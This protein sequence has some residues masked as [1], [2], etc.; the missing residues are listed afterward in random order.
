M[1]GLSTGGVH[2]SRIMAGRRFRMDGGDQSASLVPQGGAF[3]LVSRPALAAAGDRQRPRSPDLA[4]RTRPGRRGRPLIGLLARAGLRGVSL[5]RQAFPAAGSFR[6]LGFL[7]ACSSTR[8]F[9]DLLD[10]SRLS[11]YRFSAGSGWARLLQ[12]LLRT[13]RAPPL[14]VARVV[15]A[16]RLCPQELRVEQSRSCRASPGNDPAQASPPAAPFHVSGRAR[17][18]SDS[19]PGRSSGLRSTSTSM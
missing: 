11:P 9:Q 4:D 8:T 16:I 2:R 1:Q 17:A 19:Q 10:R 14:S 7:V 5:S 3:R 15:R 6:Y 18:S 13:G 12:T